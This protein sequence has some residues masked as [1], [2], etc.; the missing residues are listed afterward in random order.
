MFGQLS[1]I[2]CGFINLYVGTPLSMYANMG[3]ACHLLLPNHPAP[4]LNRATCQ[5]DAILRGRGSTVE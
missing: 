1:N 3:H 4:L 5:L 2:E